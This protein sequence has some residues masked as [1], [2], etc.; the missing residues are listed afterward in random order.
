[1][2]VH[3]VNNFVDNSEVGWGLRVDPFEMDLNGYTSELLLNE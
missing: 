2:H 1:M 3:E